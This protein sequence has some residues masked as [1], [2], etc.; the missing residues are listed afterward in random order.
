V[1]ALWQFLS[2]PPAANSPPRSHPA[3]RLRSNLILG[4]RKRGKKSPTPSTPK[5]RHGKDRWMVLSN[6]LLCTRSCAEIAGGPREGG[7]AGFL[8]LNTGVNPISAKI[9]R[10]GM[11]SETSAVRCVG[12]KAPCPPMLSSW[13]RS[14][15][16]FHDQSGGDPAVGGPMACVFLKR[17]AWIRCFTIEERQLLEIFRFRSG[18]ETPVAPLKMTALVDAAL[19][20]KSPLPSRSI[21]N[22]P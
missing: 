15:A 20:A 10:I 16:G 22:I 14:A 7:A 12:A 4:T 8:I 21:P 6:Y 2:I 17:R 5:E 9:R 18:R 11:W 13:Q 3:K 19:R 1:T